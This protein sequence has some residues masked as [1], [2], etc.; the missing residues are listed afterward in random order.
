M[1]DFELELSPKA[2][3]VKSLEADSL[4]EVLQALRNHSLVAWVFDGN[5]SIQIK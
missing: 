5:I 1:A 3:A 2:K 4:R